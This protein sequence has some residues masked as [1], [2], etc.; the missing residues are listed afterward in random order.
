MP[1][2]SLKLNLYFYYVCTQFFKYL[3]LVILLNILLEDTS[4]DK[5]KVKPS[6]IVAGLEPER[7]NELLQAIGKAVDAL[8]G[9]NNNND[10]ESKNISAAINPVSEARAKP[11]KMSQNSGEVKSKNPTKV[12]QKTTVKKSSIQGVTNSTSTSSI[13]KTNKGAKPI[14]TVEVKEKTTSGNKSLKVKTAPKDVETTTLQRSGTET[15]LRETGLGKEPMEEVMPSNHQS[16]VKDFVPVEV[17]DSKGIAGDSNNNSVKAD[18]SFLTEVF[19][20]NDKIETND[21]NLTQVLSNT[22]NNI[23]KADDDEPFGT[24]VP[25]AVNSDLIDV[26]DQEAEIRRR[27][28]S[29]RKHRERR[30]SSGHTTGLDEH[31]NS[32]A[33]DMPTTVQENALPKSSKPK[34]SLKIQSSISDHNFE[35]VDKKPM[36][37]QKSSEEPPTPLV[38]PRTSL[39]PPSVR[40][41]SARPGAPR[42]RDKNVEIFLQPDDAVQMAGISVKVDKFP[43]VNLDDDGDNLI[44]IE[45]P[46]IGVV[47]DSMKSEF[48][49]NDFEDSKSNSAGGIHDVNSDQHGHLVQQILQTQKDLVKADENDLNNGLVSLYNLF[50]LIPFNSCKNTINVVICRKRTSPRIANV[51]RRPSKWTCCV[52]PFKR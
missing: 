32:V 39:R 38:R 1:S 26:I 7:T 25:F 51:N 40:P 36:I 24:I 43:E 15:I 41:A 10:V 8:K 49:V 50:P 31:A 14:K 48:V 17:L 27:E 22:S 42:R 2:V 6:K 47:D 44:V 20:D 9:N 29:S 5:I 34:K 30:K 46:L 19:K 4:S 33:V 13:I 3:N 12:D 23:K 21:T 18:T 37:L 52:T 28:R 45:D 11:K 16:P 35:E